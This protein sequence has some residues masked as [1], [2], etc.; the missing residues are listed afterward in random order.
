[1]VT[2]ITVRPAELKLTCRQIDA[3][4]TSCAQSRNKPTL[5]EPGLFTRRR[6]LCRLAILILNSSCVASR[7]SP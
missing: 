4:L 1:M 3:V 6:I 2:V 7:M 5:C